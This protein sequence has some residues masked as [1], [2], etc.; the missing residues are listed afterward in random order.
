MFHELKNLAIILS[1][2]C[3]ASMYLAISTLEFDESLCV[4]CGKKG[5]TGIMEAIPE[6]LIDN[7]FEGCCGVL[8]EGAFAVNSALFSCWS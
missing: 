1:I 5:S 4:L 2:S 7:T 6:S 3:E 8:G